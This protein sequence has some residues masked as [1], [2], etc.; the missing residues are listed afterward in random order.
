M[1]I[2]QLINQVRI[3]NEINGGLTSKKQK[4]ILK[5]GKSAIINL[6]KEEEDLTSESCSSGDMHMNDQ[7]DEVLNPSNFSKGNKKKLKQMNH[8][9]KAKSINTGLKESIEYIVL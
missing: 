5:Y 1:E 9:I 3:S 8:K 2:T 6:G 4:E 7:L